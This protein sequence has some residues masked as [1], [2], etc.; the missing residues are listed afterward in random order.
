MIKTTIEIIKLT[1]S[2]GMVLTNGKAYAPNYVH[3]GELDNVDNW[4]EITKEE[5]DRIQ[6][7]KQRELEM[8][9]NA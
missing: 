8:H 9:T 1:P 7:E 5:Y 4:W 3:I 6:E 2:N